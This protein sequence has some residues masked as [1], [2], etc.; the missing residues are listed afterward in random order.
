MNQN[1]NDIMETKSEFYEEA[2]CDVFSGV[3]IPCTALL[4][5]ALECP[6]MKIGPQIHRAQRFYGH[7]F[8]C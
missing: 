8:E 7:K 6:Q 1:L 4:T 2:C 5:F 3:K